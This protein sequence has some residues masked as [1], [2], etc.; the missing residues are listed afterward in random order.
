[1]IKELRKK[2]RNK[3]SLFDK[4]FLGIMGIIFLA[5]C[6]RIYSLTKPIYM[7]GTVISI[8]VSISETKEEN[9]EVKL[10]ELIED[11]IFSF[12]F[13]P[14]IIGYIVFNWKQLKDKKI[15]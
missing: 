6:L 12:S 1:M 11:S 8:F 7:L 10:K 9:G 15:L 3:T 14:I 13:C 2:G 5:I 4:I